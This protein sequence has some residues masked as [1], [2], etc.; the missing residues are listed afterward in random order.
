MSSTDVVVV[1]AGLA[2]LTAARYLQG[3]GLS[4]TVLEATDR[5]GG[6]VKSDYVGGFIL[7]HGFQVI[8]PR[9]REVRKTE[10]LHGAT[11]GG[12]RKLQFVP[13]GAG[14]EI[15]NSSSDLK[16]VGVLNAPQLGSI[17]E[18]VAFLNF[19][20]KSEGASTLGECAK[21]FPELY[22]TYLRPFLQGVFLGNPDIEDADVARTILKSFAFGRPGV[23]A[24]GVQAFSDA[25]AKP[26]LDI[27]YS[28]RVLD[29]DG[30][31]VRTSK[32]LYK[33]KFVIVAVDPSSVQGLIPHAP[34]VKMSA[35]TTWYHSLPAGMLTS[36]ALRVSTEGAIINSLVIS[37]RAAGYAPIGKSLLST[38]TLE[39]VSEK[40][41]TKSLAA[42]WGV[43][44]KD[45]QL[46][47]HHEIK[48][49]LPVHPMGKTLLSDPRIGSHTF[50][51]GDYMAWP[52]QQGAMLS[53]RRAAELVIQQAR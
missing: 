24:R 43:S 19:L 33:A 1:G 5:P 26:V 13:L 16:S 9:Y 37:N 12:R 11:F 3:A 35:S 27:R 28:E 36:K 34:K 50:L 2:G 48:N 41:L 23:P 18:K 46:V 20:R 14:F 15:Y 29:I 25:L 7:D 53:G 22:S 10:I 6:R 44:E 52:S 38:T 4:V 17:S 49:S 51:A 8:N 40:K 31:T 39:K 47:A 32:G 30:T 21:K 42:M 45:L